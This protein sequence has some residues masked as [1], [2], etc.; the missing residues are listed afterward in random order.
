MAGFA[1]S[2]DI[3]FLVGFVGAIAALTCVTTITAR[4][5]RPNASNAAVVLITG[6]AFPALFFALGLAAFVFIPAGNSPDG[7]AML[8]AGVVGLTIVALPIGLITSV[9]VVS[10]RRR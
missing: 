7:P 9:V 3:P 8:F 6:L 5:F 2:G 10:M 1:N 4:R